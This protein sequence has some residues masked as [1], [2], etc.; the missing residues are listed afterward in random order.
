MG[1]ICPFH[2]MVSD[3]QVE[4][5]FVRNKNKAQPENDG[6]CNGDYT[7]IFV[8]FSPFNFL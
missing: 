4:D 7:M 8:I 2:P 1:K 6:F 3:G 5:L